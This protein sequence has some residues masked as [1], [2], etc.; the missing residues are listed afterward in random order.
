LADLIDAMPDS[1]VGLIQSELLASVMVVASK[2][3]TYPVKLVDLT[4]LMLSSR[5]FKRKGDTFPNDIYDRLVKMKFYKYKTLKSDNDS[6]M[7]YDSSV[8]DF[9][10]YL[11][12][13]GLDRGRLG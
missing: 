1:I 10:N 7:F 8:K 11:L 5:G 3:D 4:P 9:I 12:L 13:L 6:L 2:F